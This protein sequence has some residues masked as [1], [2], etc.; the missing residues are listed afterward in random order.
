MSDDTKMPTDPEMP[1]EEVAKEEETEVDGG[2]QENQ[3]KQE[4]QE[5][6]QNE[7]DGGKKDKKEDKKKDKKQGGKRKLSEWNLFVKKVYSD[8]KMKNKNFKFKDALVLA[9]KMMNKTKKAKK[10]KAPKQTRRR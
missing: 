10:T 9:S 5:N 7:V 8:E 6:E 1:K 3:Q 4:K 2:K